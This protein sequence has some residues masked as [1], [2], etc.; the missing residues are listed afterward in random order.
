MK[1]YF[2]ALI[3]TLWL[4]VILTVFFVV[5]KP[6]FLK[7]LAGLKNL[8]LIVFIPLWMAAL[9]ACIGTYL[10]PDS[11]SAER[12][13]FGAAIGMGIFGLAGFGLA[14]LGLAKPIILWALLLALTGFFSGTGKLS[15]VGKDV[16]RVVEEIRESAEN[17][18]HWIP[19]GLSIAIGLAFLMSLTP[20]IEDFDALLY[21]L[22]V[23]AL[24]LRDGGLTSN[25]ALTYWYPHIVEGS[26]VF[27]LALGVDAAAHLIHLFWL[28]LTLLIL[29]RWARQVW[30]DA[31]AW[32]AVAIVL[33]MP[34][35]LWLASWAYTDYALT[36]SGVAALYAIWK[37]RNAE[38]K[39]WIAIGGVMAGLAMGMK[40]TSF[41]IPLVCVALIFIWEEENLRRFKSAFQ[42]SLA[43][44]L[45]AFP[46][47]LRNWAWTGNPVYPFVFG[48]RF[49]DSFLAQRFSGAGSG[50]GFDFAALLALPLTA[51]L[52]TRDTNYFDGRFGPLFLILF[53]VTLWAYWRAYPEK[54]EQRRALLALHLLSLGGAAVWTFGV[55]NSAKLIQARYLFPALIPA[56]IPLAIG[57]N[58]LY[59]LDA[60]KFKVSFIFR[61]MMAF[62]VFVNLLD[63][64]LHTLIR[65]PIAVSLGMIPR[66]RYIEQRQP[67]YANAL[68][69]VNQVPAD[70]K[71]YFLFE[72]RSYGATVY[73]EPDIINSHFLHDLWL[74]ETPEKVAAAWKEQGYTHIL[75]STRGAEFFLKNNTDENLLFE[76][77]KNLLVEISETQSGDYVL[78]ELP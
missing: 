3:F 27:P 26:F 77:T 31:I 6:D 32:D 62:L 59:K 13:I 43:A 60:P 48:G 4:A 58:A 19:I 78:Y 64:S 18:A 75:I 76:Q 68:K 1:K 52:G 17:V 9:S 74:Y 66:Q 7:L 12:L 15:R 20:P 55:M 61:T 72:P 29:W 54:I 56:A 39:K 2:L 16:R 33:T 38:D 30:S 49:W 44:A 73:A 69:L 71:I 14:I 53:P 46:W 28:A 47:Y 41:V 8:F 70:S 35:L 40:Y 25:Q 24:W 45:V 42:F 65:N 57:L 10:L 63:F 37:W 34:S 36:F 5:Q 22:T 67:G 23:P 50:I 51:T 21:H 11:D